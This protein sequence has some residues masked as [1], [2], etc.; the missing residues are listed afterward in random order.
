MSCI[1]FYLISEYFQFIDLMGSF[2]NEKA[3]KSYTFMYLTKDVTAYSI[4]TE[5]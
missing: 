1:S 4:S 3:H 5:I 2:R